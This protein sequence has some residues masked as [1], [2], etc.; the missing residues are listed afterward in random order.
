MIDKYT[1]ATKIGQ[2]IKW[3]VGKTAQHFNISNRSANVNLS[4]QWKRDIYIPFY[5]NEIILLDFG[6]YRI[7]LYICH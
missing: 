6:E 4:I 3:N 2:S 5:W 1:I 7:P